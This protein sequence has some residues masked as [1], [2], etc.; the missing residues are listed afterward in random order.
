M[1]V[2][3]LLR[4]DDVAQR[5]RHLAARPRRARS[6]GSAPRRRARGRGCRSS[7]AARSGTSRDAGRSPRGRAR[8]AMPGRAARSSTKAWVQPESNQTSRMSSPARSRRGRSSLPRK[9]AGVAVE[10]GV[11]ALGLEGVDDAL[12]APR[13]RAAARRSA[14]ATNTAIGTPQAR[15]RET[16]QSGR[17]SIMAR[18]RFCPRAGTKRVASIAGS[19]VVAQVRCVSMGMNHCGVLRKI[20]GALERQEC[21]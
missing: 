21:G 16:H 7:P 6:R 3:T 4:R 5:L 11:G 20:S 17:V 18:S 9:R 15:W 14:C 10:P 13:G 12:A 1:L 2:A 8:P 19:A